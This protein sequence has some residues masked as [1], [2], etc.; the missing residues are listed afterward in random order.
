MPT[1][2]LELKLDAVTKPAVIDLLYRLADDGLI[3]GHRNSEWTGIGPI[4]E[5]DIAFSSV[6][7]DKMGHALAFYNLLHELGEPDADQLA[8]FRDA[9]QFRCCSL[10]VLENYSEDAP[11]EGPDLCNNP[12]RDRLVAHGD[13]ALSLVRQFLFSE[14][15]AV[16]MAALSDSAF[17]PLARIA[18]KIRGEIKYHTMHGRSMMR[19][20]GAAADETRDR[21]QAEID[22]LWPY[23]LGIF[24]P[25]PHDKVLAS[26]GISPGES[27]LCERWKAEVE[28]ILEAAGFDV[29]AGARPVHGGRSGRH[30][31]EMALLLGDLQRVAREHPGAKW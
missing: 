5:E 22:R 9:G 29:P 30:P 7:Q 14:A 20:M 21:I 1:E 31:A 15:D 24:E 12:T 6:A 17:V 28:P 16:R 13:W 18:R 19:H 3:I 2:T 27:E 4:L 23:A 8:F 10:V 26:C 11:K 25:T